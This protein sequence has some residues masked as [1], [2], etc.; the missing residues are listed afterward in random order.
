MRMDEAKNTIIEAL[1]KRTF[2]LDEGINLSKAFGLY[3]NQYSGAKGFIK[4]LGLE[5]SDSALLKSM[6]EKW[7]VFFSG[8][9]RS[10]ERFNIARRKAGELLPMLPKDITNLN[11]NLM[12][13]GRNNC[14]PYLRDEA[15]KF[16]ISELS[17]FMVGAITREHPTIIQLISGFFY[18]YLD[19]YYSFS[20]RLND[21]KFYL[22]PMI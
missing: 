9:G 19:R 14:K 13:A 21:E 4:E 22:M 12:R 18:L 10:D 6:A 20:T 16:N 5:E 17:D 8:C 3:F 15:S 7:I 11:E 1:N 2:T